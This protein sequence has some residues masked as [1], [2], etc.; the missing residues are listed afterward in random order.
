MYDKHG[1]IVRSLCDGTCAD[2]SFR[3]LAEWTRP[4]SSVRD[5]RSVGYWQ[6]SCAHQLG[7]YIG[8][9]EAFFRIRLQLTYHSP[10]MSVPIS[11]PFRRVSVRYHMIIVL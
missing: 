1:C 4:S 8:D 5:D 11:I 9:R 3:I 6:P 10:H 2:T 7:V